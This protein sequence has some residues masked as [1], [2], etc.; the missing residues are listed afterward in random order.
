MSSLRILPLPDPHHLR[1]T[2]ERGP[3]VLLLATLDIADSALRIQHPALDRTSQ[4]PR[5]CP[6]VT[7]L[8]AELLLC[9]FAELSKIVDHYN[10]AVDDA[11]GRDDLDDLDD[12]L[13]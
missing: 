10:A 6:P 11:L 13:F 1:T 8:L 2:P 4:P 7:E 3:L 12:V 5:P 9:R